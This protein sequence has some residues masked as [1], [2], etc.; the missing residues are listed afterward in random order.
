VKGATEDGELGSA[1]EALRAH[2]AKLH[3]EQRMQTAQDTVI[4]FERQRHGSMACRPVPAANITLIGAD[5]EKHIVENHWQAS[6]EQVDSSAIDVPR[7]IMQLV[8]DGDFP[9]A[10]LFKP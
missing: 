7:S 6:P 1:G 8:Q 2:I 4:E 10:D 3:S 9:V 5:L